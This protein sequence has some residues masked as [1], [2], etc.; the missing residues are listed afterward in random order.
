VSDSSAPIDE[1]D[2]DDLDADP[3]ADPDADLDA[4][5]AAKLATIRRRSM[6]LVVFAILAAVVAIVLLPKLP[7]PQRV[8]LHVGVGASNVTSMTARIG[9]ADSN[10]GAKTEWDREA[11]WRFPAGAPPS[12]VWETEHVDGP[13]DLEVELS[14][15]TRT[16][17]TRAQIDLKSGSKEEPSVTLSF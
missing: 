5:R 15:P 12:I 8:R 6:Q 14:S 2:A 10:G 1:E 11:T 4:A 7:H 9:A 16:E 3:D 17:T 13:C